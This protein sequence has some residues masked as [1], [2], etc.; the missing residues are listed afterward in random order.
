MSIFVATHPKCLVK[1][2]NNLTKYKHIMTTINVRIM[3]RIAVHG[4]LDAEKD[5]SKRITMF[6]RRTSFHSLFTGVLLIEGRFG[7]STTAPP[8]MV[9]SVFETSKQYIFLVTW[10]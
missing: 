8:R 3:S 9:Y 4:I 10:T 2:K 6:K 7:K 5:I 1:S